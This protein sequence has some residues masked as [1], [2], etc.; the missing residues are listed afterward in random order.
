MCSNSNQAMKSK[1]RGK[2]CNTGPVYDESSRAGSN[3]LE[4]F[5]FLINNNNYKHV[6][7]HLE[8]RTFEED[9][10]LRKYWL[11]RHKLFSR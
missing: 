7:S 5:T 2:S 11:Y 1:S 3:F 9:R 10:T 4:T 8:D 6:E